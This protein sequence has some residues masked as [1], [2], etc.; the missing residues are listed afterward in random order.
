MSSGPARYAQQRGK[1]HA[2]QDPGSRLGY[3]R[4]PVDLDHVRLI[5]GPGSRERSVPLAARKV[6]EMGQVSWAV[7]R[8]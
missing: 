3:G 8:A 2:S 6:R 5:S 1:S 7:V 4:K